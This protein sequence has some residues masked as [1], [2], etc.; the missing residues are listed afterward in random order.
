[1]VGSPQRPFGLQLWA[2]S[3]CAPLHAEEQMSNE[4]RLHYSSEKCRLQ[5]TWAHCLS[6][7]RINTTG[8]S[9][10]PE[11]N[12]SWS[13][14]DGASRSLLSPSPS[15]THPHSLAVAGS[16]S[17][18]LPPLGPASPPALQ[19]P[20]PQPSSPVPGP[21][22]HWS[23]GCCPS[24]PSPAAPNPPACPAVSLCLPSGHDLLP[25]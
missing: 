21:A 7:K 16:H 15:P 22:G 11:A 25:C 17:P 2:G 20:L 3:P 1:M 8:P 14:K 5:L 23:R 12:P 13:M 18:S 10:A 6:H 4:Q 9:P 19:R 24:A